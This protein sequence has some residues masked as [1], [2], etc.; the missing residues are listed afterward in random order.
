MLR[1]S[2]HWVG[3]ANPIRWLLGVVNSGKNL[4]S[5]KLRAKLECVTSV[6]LSRLLGILL[7]NLQG[8]LALGIF[9]AKRVSA[10]PTFRIALPVGSG[11]SLATRGTT[12]APA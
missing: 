3:G 6:L 7:G 1:W 4:R 5:E 12:E 9:G 11:V 2:G 8:R 10:L